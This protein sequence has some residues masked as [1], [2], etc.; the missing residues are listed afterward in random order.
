MMQQNIELFILTKRQKQLLRKPILMMYLNQFILPVISNMQTSLGKNSGWII[1]S[2]I[3]HN[4]NISSC[5]HLAG[6]SCIKLTKE[7]DH[8]QKG[9]TN[10]QNFNDNQCFK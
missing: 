10:I 1:D 8:P 4:I 5:N 7:L 2:V 9:L 6:S 3:D